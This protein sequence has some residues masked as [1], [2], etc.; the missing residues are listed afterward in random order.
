MAPLVIAHGDFHP[1][2]VFLDGLRVVAIDLDHYFEGDPVWDVAY[3]ASQIQ[4]SAF[5]KR[6]DFH[7]FDHIVTH[8]IES[9]LDAHAAYD[10][11]SFYHRLAIYRARAL[12]ESL[13]YELCVLKTGKFGIVETFLSEC[14]RGLD[15][16]SHLSAA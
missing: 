10:R 13:H 8:F 14:K 11:A 4:V 1:K 6:G 16:A 3:L 2:N 7:Y 9:Y 12:L 15:G 5:L